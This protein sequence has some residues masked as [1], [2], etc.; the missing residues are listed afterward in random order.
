MKEVSKIEEL[1]KNMLDKEKELEEIREAIV[2]GE[3]VHKKANKT[4]D[5]KKNANDYRKQITR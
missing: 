1:E 4:L 5:S 2:V 3:S